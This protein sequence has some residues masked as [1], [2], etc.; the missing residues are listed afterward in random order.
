MLRGPLDYLFQ[1]DLADLFVACGHLPEHIGP[2][3]HS[4]VLQLLPL[5]VG[6][7][8]DK[9]QGLIEPDHRRTLRRDDVEKP[10]SVGAQLYPQ[11]ILI[12]DERSL[13]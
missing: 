11:R 8:S 4:A 6:K 7:S 1:V 9:L 12:L 2:A 3:R 10:V 5:R 13:V